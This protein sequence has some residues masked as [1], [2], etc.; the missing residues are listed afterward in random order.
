MALKC[1]NTS[2]PSDC[3]MNP[4]PLSALNHFTVPVATLAIPLVRLTGRRGDCVPC[5]PLPCLLCGAVL[6][7]RCQFPCRTE[8][9][10]AEFAAVTGGLR[11]G[12]RRPPPP[13]RRAEA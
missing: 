6:P 4:K 7:C 3:E 13:N 8:T 12:R 5:L 11:C 10:A 2:A 9:V 1:T